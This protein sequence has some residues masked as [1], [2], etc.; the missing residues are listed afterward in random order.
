MRLN[1]LAF[2][3]LDQ[4]IRFDA[5]D[6]RQQT[7][8]IQ[9][10]TNGSPVV[11]AETA[12]MRMPVPVWTDGSATIKI[13]WSEY[14]EITSSD[15]SSVWF[16]TSSASR[17]EAHPLVYTSLDTKPKTPRA[18]LEIRR[19]IKEAALYERSAVEQASAVLRMKLNA[20]IE[21]AQAKIDALTKQ[22]EVKID[23]DQDVVE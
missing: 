4:G 17:S 6:G 5:A 16:A 3:L 18:V 14:L 7:T 10:V 19:Q 11:W 12:G 20:Q 15:G 9:F 22:V 8:E 23:E 1:P 21:A 13:S 2:A